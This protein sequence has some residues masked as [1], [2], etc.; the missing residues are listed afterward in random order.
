ML[1]PAGWPDALGGLRGGPLPADWT[2]ARRALR[3]CERPRPSRRTD[4]LHVST[5]V[6]RLRS[7]VRDSSGP[8]APRRRLSPSLHAGGGRAGG[9]PGGGN[10]EHRPGPADRRE[11]RARGGVL[12]ELP[13]SESSLHWAGRVV[14]AI[15]LAVV[16][17]AALAVGILVPTAL[18]ICRRLAAHLVQDGL[19]RAL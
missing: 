7:Q 12:M 17:A 10:P 6:A 14:I 2:A 18:P 8:R 15:A 19:S 3:G 13:S 16:F 1:S 9:A 4:P 11:L 5:S